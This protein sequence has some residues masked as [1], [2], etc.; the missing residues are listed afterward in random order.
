M[1][2]WLDVFLFFFEAKLY[3]ETEDPAS[4]KIRYGSRQVSFSVLLYNSSI[5]MYVNER[6]TYF[7]FELNWYWLSWTGMGKK[8]TELRHACLGLWDRKFTGDPEVF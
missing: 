2:K 5:D 7:V 4:R 8:T 1:T 6:C 3:I